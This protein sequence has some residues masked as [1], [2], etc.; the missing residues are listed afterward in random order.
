VFR[1]KPPKT[2]EDIE[3]AQSALVEMLLDADETERKRL[4]LLA[5]QSGELKMSEANDVVRLVERLEKLSGK[6]PGSSSK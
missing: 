1:R 2:Q 4:L 5:L 6:D 3:D